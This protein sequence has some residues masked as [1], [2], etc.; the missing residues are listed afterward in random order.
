MKLNRCM[1]TFALLVMAATLAWGQQPMS[2]KTIVIHAGRLLDVK[3]GKTLTSQTIVIQSDKIV[4]VGAGAQIP[5]DATIIDLPNATVLPGLIDAHT[6][7]TFTPNF[8][9]S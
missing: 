7:I 5:P 6:H 8:G 4:S 3:T 2:V 1:T 9:Y